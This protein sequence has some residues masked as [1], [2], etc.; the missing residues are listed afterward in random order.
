M[1]ETAAGKVQ[2]RHLAREACLYIRQSS[3]KQVA[4]NTESTHRQYDLRRSAIALGWSEDRIRLIDDDQGLSGAY[5]ANRSGFRDLTARIAAGEIGIVLC[6]EVSRL[7]RDNCDWAQLVQFARLADTLILDEYGVHDPNDSSDKLLLDIKGSLSEFELAGIR[8]RLLGGQRSK[9]A[10]GELRVPLPLGLVYDE[11]GQVVFDPDRQVV[12]AIR[13]VFTAFRDKG[14]AMQVVKWF[15]DENILLPHRARTGPCRGVLRWNLPDHP[16][17]RRIL[18][19][20]A[21]AGAFAY[22]QT[23]IL[24]QAD[25]SVRYRTLPLD[26]WEVCI[27]GHHVGF[28]DWQEYGRNLATLARNGSCFAANPARLSAPRNGAALLQGIALCGQ[29]GGRLNVKYSRARPD[30]NQPAQVHYTCKEATVRKGEKGCLWIRAEAVD[31]AVGRFAVA[32]MNGE[33]IAL[34][35]AVQEQVRADFAE[36][37]AQRALR[38]ERLVYEAELAQRRYYA[39]DP[40]NRLVAAPLEA[41]WNEGLRELE[42][43]GRE[44]EERQAA[45]DAEMSAEQLRRIEELA[46]DFAQVWDAPTT[47]HA[48]RKRLLRLLVEDAT[49]TRAGYEVRV[50][51]RL[52]GGKALTLDQVQLNRPRQLKYPL[53]P[54]AV[55]ALDA[56]L[57]THSD[58]EAAELLNQAGHRLWNGAPYTLR[59]VY[60]LRQRV[61]MKGHLQR[62]REQLRAQ[63]Y[64]TVS[65]LA[66]QLGLPCWSVQAL[67]RQGRI[68][69]DQIKAAKKPRS[70]YKLP[71]GYDQRG[72]EPTD[73]A[74]Q[75]GRD[76]S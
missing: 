9:A 62:R 70:M 43:A 39:A 69:C 61:A 26:E 16:K 32:A 75:F 33:N 11:D 40:V 2:P 45:R 47:D 42:E 55:A 59:H 64:V 76:A 24:R 5:A 49:L 1:L 28:I 20:P 66:S 63:G 52:R 30:R 73:A 8:A 72:A 27:P 35:L 65:E 41:A 60:R 67:A 23:R 51:L 37:D 19:N 68:L 14:S 74:Q 34:A 17:I 48:D 46:R 57:D 50:D 38:I 36:A 25:G 18:R 12:A 58:A 56:A 4:C 44:R 31:A 10:R 29:C 3:L 54:A 15:R 22:G 7:A 71:A 53:C 6:L 21:Y 13:R